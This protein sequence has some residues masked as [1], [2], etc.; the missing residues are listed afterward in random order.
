M[1]AA[2]I[3]GQ[4]LG[5]TGARSAASLTS[6]FDVRHLECDAISPLTSTVVFVRKA[7]GVRTQ[8]GDQ[9]FPPEAAID[10]GILMIIVTHQQLISFQIFCLPRSTFEYSVY[11][12]VST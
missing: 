11:D 8:C 3:I 5:D 10:K 9:H 4:S 7:Y 2:G 12:D 1:N 6:P